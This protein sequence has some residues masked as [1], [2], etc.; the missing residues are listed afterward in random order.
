FAPIPVTDFSGFWCM[1]FPF[2]TWLGT[3]SL[4]A[5]ILMLGLFVVSWLIYY[6]FYKVYEKQEI[7]N[8]RIALESK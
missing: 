6:P 5:V 1:P 4:N 7:E 8:E 3:Q 2:V